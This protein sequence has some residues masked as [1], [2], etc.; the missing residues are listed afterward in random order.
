MVTVMTMILVLVW[1][2]VNHPGDS[3]VLVRPGRGERAAARPGALMSMSM[4]MWMCASLGR[5]RRARVVATMLG[6]VVWHVGV[7]VPFA[8]VDGVL[9]W[10]EIRVRMLGM[11]GVAMVLVGWVVLVRT[12]PRPVALGRAIF[13]GP[14]RSTAAASAI[15]WAL[16][17]VAI[18]V[19]LDPLALLLELP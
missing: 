2:E 15:L 3:V 18:R 8:R 6:A 4:W 7:G 17:C 14:R 13:P 9:V 1:V 12:M 11:G 19:L 10:V 16:R 5:E